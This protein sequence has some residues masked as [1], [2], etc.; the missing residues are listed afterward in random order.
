MPDWMSHI[1]V[2][3]ILAELFSIRKKSLVLLGALLPDLVPRLGLLFFYLGFKSHF[4]LGAFHYPVV[5]ILAT[6]PIALL[7]KYNRTYT[8]I[9]LNIG[10]LS[11][12][13][14]DITQRHFKAGMPIF[15][16]FS[17]KLYTLNWF[18]P[19]QAAF[20]FLI[21]GLFVY[22]FIRLVKKYGVTAGY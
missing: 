10:V 12:F 9:S 2:G 15:F 21:M 6:V 7:F 18:W 17:T 11:H 14:I 20:Y 3:L 8:I 4:S 16:P 22:G 19:E 13:I 5:C 1:L